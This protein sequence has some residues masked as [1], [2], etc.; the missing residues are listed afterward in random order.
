MADQWAGAAGGECTKNG[1]HGQFTYWLVVWLPSILFSHSYWVSIIIPLDELI[2]FRGV[3]LA[4]QPDTNQ[5]FPFQAV[6]SPSVKEGY[7]MA[8]AVRYTQEEAIPPHHHAMDGLYKS[9]EMTGIS[10]CVFRSFEHSFILNSAHSC[11]LLGWP[12]PI[13]PICSPCFLIFPIFIL[14]FET[15]LHRW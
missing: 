5:F 3:A 1:C 10:S 6:I 7:L 4:H 13:F 11:F 15:I 14:C 2:F 8:F 9:S 12:Y